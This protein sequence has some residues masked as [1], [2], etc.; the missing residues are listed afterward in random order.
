MIQYSVKPLFWSVVER[1]FLVKMILG[2]VFNISFVMVPIENRLVHPL[3][4]IPDSGG[5]RDSILLFY[6]NIIWANYL[7][8]ESSSLPIFKYCVCVWENKNMRGNHKCTI[9]SELLDA[10]VPSSQKRNITYKKIIIF[11]SQIIC[12]HT[13]FLLYYESFEV[14]RWFPCWIILDKLSNLVSYI[15]L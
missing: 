4:V 2:T 11:Q 15:F 5:D 3:C 9:A 10:T 8:N 1:F 7:G 13:Y 6:Q 12:L 14:F